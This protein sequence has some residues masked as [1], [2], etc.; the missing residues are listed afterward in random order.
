MK[1]R[2]MKSYT[3]K[4]QYSAKPMGYKDFCVYMA[5]RYGYGD[6]NREGYIIEDP[7]IA[8]NHPSH[9]FGLFWLPKKKFEKD[10]SEVD[11]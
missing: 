3:R 11:D 6:D 4:T 7:N 10:Y 9:E 2:D 5:Y 8:S 1:S